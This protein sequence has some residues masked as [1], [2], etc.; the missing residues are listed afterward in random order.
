MID[1]AVI[2]EKLDQMCR[3]DLRALLLI[4]Q[5]RRQ[6]EEAGL[7]FEASMTE[8]STKRGRLPR[9]LL[10]FRSGATNVPLASYWPASERWLW[11]REQGKCPLLEIVPLIRRKLAPFACAPA[12]EQDTV[13][14]PLPYP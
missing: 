11:G 8:R 14:R 7:V 1:A 3:A 6:A 5:V 4:D 13:V 12:R 10:R 2:A 9:L